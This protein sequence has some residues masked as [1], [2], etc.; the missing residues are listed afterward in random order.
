MAKICVWKFYSKNCKDSEKHKYV[1][2]VYGIA[3]DGVNSWSF[4]NDYATNVVIFGFDNSS[5]SHS[6][7][8]KNNF[9]ILRE[10]LTHNINGS[11]GSLEKSLVLI[12]L[13]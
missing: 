11:F 2:S 5:L 6:N 1:Y 12:L 10:G 4:G 7:N 13:K 9:L 8:H 3:F